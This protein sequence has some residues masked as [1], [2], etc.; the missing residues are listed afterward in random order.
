MVNMN[1]PREE[2]RFALKAFPLPHR[3]DSCRDVCVHSGVPAIS[4]EAWASRWLVWGLERAGDWV[5]C[6]QR[7]KREVLLEHS[8]VSSMPPTVDGSGATAQK[9]GEKGPAQ[10]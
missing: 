5:F 8:Q 10:N 3:G 7:E 2:N 1:S 6:P 4:P 9:P